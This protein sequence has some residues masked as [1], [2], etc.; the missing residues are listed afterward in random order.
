MDVN[1]EML[2]KELQGEVMPLLNSLHQEVGEFSDWPLV[3]DW[4][5]YEYAQ[6]M[7]D[8]VIITARRAGEL[9][10]VLVFLVSKHAHYAGRKFAMQ[11][12]V[13]VA[14]EL[15]GK[16]T[17]VRMFKAAERMLKAIGVEA[18]TTHSRTGDF[19]FG[20]FLEALGCK[21]SEITYMKR[22]SNG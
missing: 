7:G 20:G 11:D 10:G 19:F 15:R 2:T 13:Y 12:I 21:P 22:L 3:V 8:I 17:A 18:Y 4:I 16:M 1:S 6:K 14:P 5:P 9:L